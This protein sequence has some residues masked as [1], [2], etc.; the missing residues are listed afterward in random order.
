MVRLK[1]DTFMPLWMTENYTVMLHD[2]ENSNFT[3]N[4]HCSSRSIP[5]HIQIIEVLCFNHYKIK[6]IDVQTAFTNIC[7][8]M[9]P[10]QQL[11]EFLC[12]TV[13]GCHLC[14]KSSCEIFSLLNIHTVNC[15][16]YYNKVEAT[17]KDTNSATKW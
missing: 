2:T 14:N 13:I 4:I 8:R 17:G 5:S 15:S 16:C 10:S 9:G 7:E 1:R 11:G 3:L 6:H 12:G